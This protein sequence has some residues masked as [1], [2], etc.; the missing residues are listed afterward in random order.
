MREMSESLYDRLGGKEA[1]NAAVDIFYEKV[2][3]DDRIRH[4]FDSVDMVRQKG[5][6]KAFMTMAFGGPVKYE[7]KDMREAHK[8]LE[9]LNEG[10]FVAVAENLKATL[11]QLSVPAE[12]IDEVMT[13]VGSTHDD[14]LNL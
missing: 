7:G 3:A 8:H 11:E 13:I 2:L 4:F 1:V 9:G 5:K 14:V 6:Q 12:M 10:H